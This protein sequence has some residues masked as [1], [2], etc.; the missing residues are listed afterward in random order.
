MKAQPQLTKRTE[1]QKIKVHET[2]Q[3][4]STSTASEPAWLALALAL[5]VLTAG[6]YWFSNRQG[7]QPNRAYQATVEAQSID[8]RQAELVPDNQIL[9]DSENPTMARSEDLTPTPSRSPNEQLVR[10]FYDEVVNQRQYGVMD[11]LFADQIAYE[12]N[13][14]MEC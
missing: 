2:E 4:A 8:E 7:L 12:R 6:L 1:A 9:T 3:T 13:G 10:R 14:P 11:D 5:L